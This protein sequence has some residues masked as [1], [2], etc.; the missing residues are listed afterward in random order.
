MSSCSSQRFTI[1]F[2]SGLDVCG[3]LILTRL[4]PWNLS[5]NA[6]CAARFGAT[7]F[8]EAALQASMEFIIIGRDMKASALAAILGILCCL[9][10]GITQRLPSIGINSRR[11]RFNR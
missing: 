10:G 5:G 4:D 8:D 7:D 6:H 2:S 3:G 9:P 11:C 1:L